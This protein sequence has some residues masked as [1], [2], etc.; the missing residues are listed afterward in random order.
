MIYNHNLKIQLKHIKGEQEINN[1]VKIILH[2]I[3]L[4]HEAILGL[5]QPLITEEVKLINSK[6]SL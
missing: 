1:L 6:C 5:P 3:F 4:Y 2:K